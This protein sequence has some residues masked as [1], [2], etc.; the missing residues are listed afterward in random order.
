MATKSKVGKIAAQAARVQEYLTVHPDIAEEVLLENLNITR[1]T[2]YHILSGFSDDDEICRNGEFGIRVKGDRLTAEKVTEWLEKNQGYRKKNLPRQSERLL[3]LYQHLHNALPD[4]GLT[5]TQLENYYIDLIERSGGE[6]G[7][8]QTLQRM[9]YRDLKSL[10]DIGIIIDRPST[11]SKDNRYCLRDRYLPKLAPE[12]AAAVYVSMLLFRDTVLDQATSRAKTELE[13][14]FFKHPLQNPAVLK[15]RIHIV[16]DTL[17]CPEQ[18]GNKFGKIVRAVA[19]NYR[20]KMTYVKLSGEVS[21]RLVEPVG[22]VCKRQV[23]YLVA[24]QPADGEYRIF[25]VDQIE[26]VYPRESEIF[27]YPEGFTV[28]DYVGSSW[29]VFKNDPVQTVLLKFSPEVAPRVKN[30]RYHWTQEIVKEGADG[31]I[32]V[33]FEVCGLIELRSWLLQWG[34]EVIV[35]KPKQLGEEVA[36]AAQAVVDMYKGL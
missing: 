30:L 21:E 11:G 25:R 10:E 1:N 9:I 22:L 3:Y 16:S 17:A 19:Y 13:R 31:S 4:G 29:G 12:S 15:D 33:K 2:L 27:E 8:Q 7:S 18:F 35:L 14:A 5:I 28:S 26:D 23:W 6:P 36:A 20:I 24:R 34:T 32:I